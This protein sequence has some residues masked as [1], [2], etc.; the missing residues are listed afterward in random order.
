MLDLLRSSFNR[1]WITN[2]DHETPA[3]KHNGIIIAR[4]S[5]NPRARGRRCRRGV[6]GC[7]WRSRWCGWWESADVLGLS[8]YHAWPRRP[9]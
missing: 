9:P 2:I 4:D 3:G 1:G 7:S 5:P 6:V 8:S